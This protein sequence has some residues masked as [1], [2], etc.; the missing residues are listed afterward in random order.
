MTQAA[1]VPST[2]VRLRLPPPRG[3]ALRLAT[4]VLPRSYPRVRAEPMAADGARSLPGRGHRESSSPCRHLHQRMQI[5]PAGSILES[6]GGK[7]L[8]SA[9]AGA[10]SNAAAAPIAAPSRKNAARSPALVSQADVPQPK[11]NCSHV[12]DDGASV[13]TGIRGAGTAVRLVAGG[14]QE[15]NRARMPPCKPVSGVHNHSGGLCRKLQFF[16]QLPGG[17]RPAQ[18]DIWCTSASRSEDERNR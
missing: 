3:L 5:K 15:E 9:E 6:S 2:P 13:P 11:H 8:A 1:V 17:R 7:I 18:A 4:G 16:A 10:I 14:D 12:L